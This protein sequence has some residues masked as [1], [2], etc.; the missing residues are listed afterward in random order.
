VFWGV[1]L[2]VYHFLAS[3]SS[4]QAT[5]ASAPTLLATEPATLPETE[6]GGLV[7]QGIVQQVALNVGSYLKYH[8]SQWEECKASVAQQLGHP[9]LNE[10]DSCHNCNITSEELCLDGKALKLSF[11]PTADSSA[12]VLAAP[13]FIFP[14]CPS[15]YNKL[16]E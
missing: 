7:G 10:M 14:F 2:S 9:E 5:F 11:T 12:F 13:E 8:I 6:S 3:A 16:G 15:C 4:K 1:A